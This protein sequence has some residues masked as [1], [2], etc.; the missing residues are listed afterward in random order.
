VREARLAAARRKNGGVKRTP[1]SLAKL[2]RRRHQP[3]SEMAGGVTAILY[4]A[5]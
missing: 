2:A 5:A 4:R 1:L 3:D